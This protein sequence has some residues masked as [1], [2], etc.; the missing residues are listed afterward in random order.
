MLFI[1]HL[2]F[3]QTHHND[4]IM[5]R[6]DILQ[7]HVHKVLQCLRLHRKEDRLEVVEDLKVHLREVNVHEVQVNGEQGHEQF[8]S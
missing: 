4:E 6:L 3:V 7:I 2:Q 1:R 5:F 8:S